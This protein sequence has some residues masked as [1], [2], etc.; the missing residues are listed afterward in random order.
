MTND[1]PNSVACRRLTPGICSLV[2]SSFQVHVV[3]PLLCPQPG[4][5]CCCLL[6]NA[7]TT[8]HTTILPG[9]GVWRQRIRGKPEGKERGKGSRIPDINLSKSS[10]IPAFC[11]L[12][13]IAG[14]AHLLS[15]T[16]ARLI[17]Y[18]ASSLVLTLL[19]FLLFLPWA[20]LLPLK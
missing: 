17:S 8:L 14:L 11:R 13:P 15:H 19:L 1:S 2:L 6:G 12:A 7:D 5:G 18:S 16:P 20:P 10:S 9:T 3:L 4:H